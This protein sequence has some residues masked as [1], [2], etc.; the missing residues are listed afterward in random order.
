MAAETES[1]DEQEE[2]RPSPR[3][4][5]RLWLMAGAMAAGAVGLALA[6]DLT[7]KGAFVRSVHVPWLVFTVGFV[8]T[9]R[10]ML[11]LQ[12]RSETHT[13]ILDEILLVLGFFVLAPTHLVAAQLVGAL[14]VLVIHHRLPILKIAVNLSQF[15]LGTVA[16][17][18]V[19]RAI[20]DPAH[21]LSERNWLAA[22]VACLVLSTIAMLA[23]GAAIAITEG[24]V[25]V[26][27]LT[28]AYVLG[29]AGTVVNT[30]LGIMAVIVLARSAYGLALL[31][32]PV[33]IVFVAYSRVPLGALEE[34]R[35]RVPLLG[36]GGAQQRA[37]LRSRPPRPPRL[38]SRHVP[39][40]SG[41]DRRERR[42]GWDR[43]QHRRW[44]GDHT[45]RAGAGRR[46]G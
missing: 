37:G 6:T 13:V 32:G 20:A 10:Y 44:S 46:Y 35:P 3:G 31:A 22:L 9:T 4:L 25:E 30:L 12:F 21:P 16:A 26:R 11:N 15:A 14:L 34:R 38:R 42:A 5:V 45:S 29:V 33:L 1:A 40:R 17:T 7:G 8:L 19:F 43:L 24:R 27:G 2:Q 23:I 39:R 18:I 36:V 41:R 28:R